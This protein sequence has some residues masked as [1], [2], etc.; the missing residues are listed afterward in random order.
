MLSSRH[1]E[2]HAV[3]RDESFWRLLHCALSNLRQ[4]ARTR[5]ITRYRSCFHRRLRPIDSNKDHRNITNSEYGTHSRSEEVAL[6]FQPCQHRQI[7]ITLSTSPR[8]YRQDRHRTNLHR[9][10]RAN[11]IAHLRPKILYEYILL[12]ICLIILM[13]YNTFI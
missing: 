11:P 10:T 3:W 6:Q 7:V 13:L 4:R 2:V 8:R 9:V 5:K 12:W 1:K